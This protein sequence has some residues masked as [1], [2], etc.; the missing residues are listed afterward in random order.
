MNLRAVGI[1]YSRGGTATDR[2]Q[3]GGRPPVQLNTV[4]VCV[5]VCWHAG[6]TPHSLL[7]NLHLCVFPAVSLPASSALVNALPSQRRAAAMVDVGSPVS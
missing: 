4:C 6:P 2:L 3:A 5:C 7:Q 1:S